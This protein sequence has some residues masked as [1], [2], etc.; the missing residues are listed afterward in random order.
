M[1]GLNTNPASLLPALMM[2]AGM[3]IY[4][5]QV[6]LISHVMTDMSAAAAAK[7]TT[8]VVTFPESMQVRDVVP[9]CSFVAT[10]TPGR[11]QV[12]LDLDKWKEVPFDYDD[13]FLSGNGVY[14]D[15]VPDDIAVAVE[16][17]LEYINRSITQESRKTANIVITNSVPLGLYEDLVKL[18]TLITSVP[19]MNRS[20]V[21]G[22]DS[23]A[24]LL[25]QA[26]IITGDYHA[27]PS[28][29]QTG[30]LTNRLG[31]NLI[32]FDDEV[33]HINEISGDISFT[34]PE[35]QVNRDHE[36]VVTTDIGNDGRKFYAGNLL[37]DQAAGAIDNTAALVVVEDS[38]AVASNTVNVKVSAAT[39]Y[40]SPAAGRVA[41]C[42]MLNVTSDAFAFSRYALGFASRP[43]THQGNASSKRLVIADQV[44]RLAFGLLHTEGRHMD[45][46]AMDSLFGT[47]VYRRY[48]LARSVQVP[49]TNSGY[50]V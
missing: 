47:Q 28:V 6:K 29:I 36:V 34:T 38:A 19:R 5:S 12:K 39:K 40:F 7:G 49:V 50:V 25:L 27:E 11:Y 13:K 18:N 8:I 1:I 14:T 23:E 46:Y 16:T 4:R 41:I 9:S 21:F 31:Y 43:T 15:I 17:L 48:G 44:N 35:I 2:A 20:A 37:I 24:S 10:G 45:C 3:A 33:T 30:V 32:P 22:V 26:P 42:K